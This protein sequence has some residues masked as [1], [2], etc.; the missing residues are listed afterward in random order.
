MSDGERTID[1]DGITEPM[2]DGQLN[3]ETLKSIY[4]NKILYLERDKRDLMD[5][6]ND[7]N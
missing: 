6:I 5:R 3:L 1:P 2:K 7:L 4:D